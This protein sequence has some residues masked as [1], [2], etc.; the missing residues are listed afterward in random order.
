MLTGKGGRWGR[1]CPKFQIWKERWANQSDP[2]PEKKR[3]LWDAPHL[4]KLINT[5]FITGNQA[6]EKA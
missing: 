6:L 4:Y 5:I 1:G 3:K 2:L